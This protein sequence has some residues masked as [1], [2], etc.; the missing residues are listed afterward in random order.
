MIPDSNNVYSTLT[1]PVD[2]ELAVTILKEVFPEAHVGIYTSGYNGAK[3]IHVDS[4]DADFEGYPTSDGARSDYLFNGGVAGSDA[5]VIAK[6]RQ[7]AERFKDAGFRMSIEAYDTRGEMICDFPEN[8][9][10]Q[11]EDDQAA[12]AV[13][14]KP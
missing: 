11:G 14:S 5:E 2:L 6:V 1:A 8:G 10:E 13:D 12:A 3:T 4:D 7:I 9:S